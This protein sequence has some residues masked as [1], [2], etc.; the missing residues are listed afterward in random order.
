MRKALCLAVSCVALTIPTLLLVSSWGH[1]AGRPFLRT[2]AAEPAEEQPKS[3]EKLT[4]EHG[5]W[6]IMVCSF[7]VSNFEHEAEQRANADKAARELVRDLR[8]KKIPAFLYSQDE[9]ESNTSGFDRAG[10]KVHLKMKERTKQLC[11]LAGN[12]P[13]FESR[14]AQDMLKKIKKMNPPC[15]K[16]AEFFRTPS[17]QTPLSGAFLTVN[18]MLTPQ[19]V[20][21]MERKS[22]PL[23][24]KL[25]SGGDYSLFRN[26]GKY[27]L[28]VATFLGQSQTLAM[29]TSAEDAVRKTAVFDA[30]L[31]SPSLDKAGEDA[32][33]LAETM[34]SQKL[35][36]YVYH[37]RYQSVVTVG[38]FDRADD[39]RMIQWAKKFG[40]K[41]VMHPQ[42]KKEVL[43]CET[44]KSAGR[45]NNAPD[46]TWLM[47]PE[48]RPMEV[49]HLK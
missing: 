3:V 47:D 22:D 2:S 39:P 49:P 13:S 17:R 1:A 37:D 45:T 38:S 12:Y 16:N 30:K 40:A 29:N 48:P 35:D 42:T 19:E 11:V 43:M 9:L 6:M 24:I 7:T 5:P 21:N 32:W 44:I 27:T 31:K 15:L 46:R 25:N 28:V 10:R 34:R 4:K 41:T 23:L 20:A 14:E 8:A 18:P 33:A 36:A 26:P